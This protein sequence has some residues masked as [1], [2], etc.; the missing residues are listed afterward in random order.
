MITRIPLYNYLPD[1]ELNDK[2]NRTQ[3]QSTVFFLCGHT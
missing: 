1:E 2:K 3:D